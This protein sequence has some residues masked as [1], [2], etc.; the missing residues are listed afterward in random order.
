M[1]KPVFYFSIRLPYFPSLI[2]VKFF[3]K[4]KN[5]NPKTICIQTNFLSPDGGKAYYHS[6]EEIEYYSN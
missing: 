5:F 3:V 4:L 6:D 1:V 2:P